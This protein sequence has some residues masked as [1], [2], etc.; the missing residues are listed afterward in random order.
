MGDTDQLA[1]RVIWPPRLPW[2][3]GSVCSLLPPYLAIGH[4]AHVWQTCPGTQVGRGGDE[5]GS[6]CLPRA[7]M[8]VGVA[9]GMAPLKTNE[10]H[11][12]LSCISDY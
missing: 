11:I 7:P 10:N 9:V 2:G 4:S 12:V 5:K 1:A 3:L 6:R 8:A